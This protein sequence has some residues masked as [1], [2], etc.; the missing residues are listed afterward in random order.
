MPEVC[1]TCGR[2]WDDAQRLGRL[3]CPDCW[4]AF[5]PRLRASLEEL[6]DG[7]VSHPN[8]PPLSLQAAAWRRG[9]LETALRRALEREDYHEAGRVRD[10]LRGLGGAA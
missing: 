5:R 2:S 8:V 7:V 10:R 3:G 9:E 4:D 6:Q 1:S